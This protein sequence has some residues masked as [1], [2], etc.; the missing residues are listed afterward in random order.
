MEAP[1][2]CAASGSARSTCDGDTDA[3]VHADPV[4]SAT[5]VRLA[6]R[7]SASTPRIAMLKLFD[8]RCVGWPFSD[9]IGNGGLNLLPKTV[10]KALRVCAVPFHLLR[11]DLAGLS[12][13]D[14]AR[15]IQRAR[16][17][18][19]LV[20]AAV[21]L[22]C[23][24]ERVALCGERTARRCPSVRTSYARSETSDRSSASLTSIG[25]LA[26][27]LGGVGVEDHAA[28]HGRSQRSASMLS[29][30]P[31][32]LLPYMARDYQNGAF[33]DAFA[34]LVQINHPILD[35]WEDT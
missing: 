26:D 15:N 19:A 30:V 18:A 28:R 4:E 25:N 17:H 32:S 9:D 27:R 24:R 31:I 22:H 10:A 8:R 13:A 3:E 5:P 35:R 14:N 23:E 11:A 1:I 33:G 12:E 20:S 6:S 21:H 29:S 2:I 16:T 34:Q 7:A